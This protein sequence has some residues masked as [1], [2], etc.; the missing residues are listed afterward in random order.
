MRATTVEPT[1]PETPGGHA[2]GTVAVTGAS[3][4]VGRHLC[5]H[6]RRRGWEVRGLVRDTASYP[7]E[8]AGVGL[9]RCDLPDVLEDGG[10]DGADVAIHC[11]YATR[12]AGLEA[13]RR[14]NEDGTRRVL[15]AARAA[16]VRRFVFVSSTSAH[17]DARSYYGR[18]KHAL[19]LLMDPR[20]DLVIR[21][22]LVLASDGG[23]FQRM[24]TLVRRTP[25]V[26][27]PGSGEQVV[28]TVHIDDL[29]SAVEQALARGVTGTLNVA[30]PDGCSMKELL[31]RVA[32]LDGSRR[33]L[34]P[35]PIAPLFH[36][37]RL[38][39]RL[40][41]PFPASSEN[42]LGLT[43]LRTVPVTADLDRIGMGVRSTA[44]S[45]ESL[46]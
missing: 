30:D 40:R 18:S 20:A 15:A 17:R 3:G 44:E 31:R 38:L 14:T 32:R 35:I 11:A 45:L 22:G 7:F 2:P 46:T 23:L 19:E 39:E 13:A 29:C 5:D 36:C 9:F 12:F 4:L 27:L 33:Y 1:A 10:F 24:R 21:P 16:G 8:E 34:L 28:Q 26:P 25:V 6:F 43:S 41:V 42:L 37:L